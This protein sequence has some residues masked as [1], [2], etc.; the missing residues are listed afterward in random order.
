MKKLM[1]VLVSM[2]LSSAALASTVQLAC[3]DVYTGVKV[4]AKIYQSSM[5]GWTIMFTTDSGYGE[6][7]RG[8]LRGN[9]LVFPDSYHAKVINFRIDASVALATPDQSIAPSYIMDSRYED[10]TKL[11]CKVI[12]R[13]QDD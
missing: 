2:T 9:D 1:M 12:D 10:F 3:K 13:R 4:S 7:L 11:N 8:H 6:S 5:S